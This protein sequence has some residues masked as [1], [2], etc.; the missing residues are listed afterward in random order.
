MPA[1]V[2]INYTE[3]CER[4]GEKGQ[5]RVTGTKRH[6]NINSM[7]LVKFVCHQVFHHDWP[8][9]IAL[10]NFMLSAGFSSP[11][12]MASIFSAYFFAATLLFSFNVGPVHIE[13][14]H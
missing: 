9:G 11:A 3:A 8:L 12:Y 4:V 2:F 7:F 6:T 13:F 1:L 10:K 14:E 5:R